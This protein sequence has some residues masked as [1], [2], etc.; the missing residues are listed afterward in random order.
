MSSYADSIQQVLPFRHTTV[1]NQDQVNLPENHREIELPA[2]GAWYSRWRRSPWAMH[3][4][5]LMIVVLAGN[6]YALTQMTT[7]QEGVTNSSILSAVLFN[8]SLAIVFRSQYMINSLFAIATA[9]PTSW[10]LR[11]R[12]SLG[13]VYHFGG[14]PV[15][16]FLAGSLLLTL[17][18]LRVVL[19]IEASSI[20]KNLIFNLVL[21]AHL[22]ILYL[23]MAISIPKFRHKYHNE[24]EVIARF[25]NWFSLLL[26]WGETYYLLSRA[27]E[28]ASAFFLSPQA[29]VLAFLTFVVALPWMKLKKVK[30]DLKR[31]S[32]HVTLANFDYG[33]TPFAGSSTDLSRNPLFEWHSFANVPAPDKDGYRLTISRAGDWTGQLIDDLPEEIWVKGIPAAGV[34]NIENLFK[35]VVWV[36]TGSGIGPCL[37]HLL[38]GKVPGRLVWSTRSPEKTYGKELVQEILEAE[39]NAIVWNTDE[40]GKPDMVKLAYQAYKDFGAE[41]VICISNPKLTWKVVQELEER[42]IPSY[43]AIWDS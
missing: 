16:G 31:P 4:Y 19:G 18:A 25:G 21:G 33:V 17:Y 2:K 32:N 24:F 30:V 15:A 27:G 35:R 6:A 37:P 36:A 13:K 5:R 8:F 39:P 34:G 7:S 10:P 40:K 11:I 12:W 22:G 38:K 42:G 43:G 23:I 3:Y 1:E 9:A 20:E 41:A 29:A 14:I 28:N 26:F